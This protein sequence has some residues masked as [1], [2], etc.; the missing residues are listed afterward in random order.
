MRDGH[1]L[2]QRGL[3]TGNSVHQARIEDIRSRRGK[4]NRP[5][6][7]ALLGDSILTLLVVAAAVALLGRADLAGT[8]S[9]AAVPGSAAT[10]DGVPAS[11]GAR[12]EPT[13]TGPVGDPTPTTIPPTATASAVGTDAGLQEVRRQVRE[14]EGRLLPAIRE[15]AM[16]AGEGITTAVAPRRLTDEDIRKAWEISRAP[17]SRQQA[18]REEYFP[19]GSEPWTVGAEINAE[20]VY[21]WGHSAEE[22]YRRY[23]AAYKPSEIRFDHGCSPQ[24]ALDPEGALACS[25]SLQP[26]GRHGGLTYVIRPEW[27]TS[28]NRPLIEYGSATGG[29]RDR[30]VT[31]VRISGTAPTREGLADL[32]VS[33]AFLEGVTVRPLRAGLGSPSWRP[34]LPTSAI[35]AEIEIEV[36]EDTTAQQPLTIEGEVLGRHCERWLSDE[37]VVDKKSRQSGRFQ[38]GKP[39]TV[40]LLNEEGEGTL[41][42]LQPGQYDLRVRLEREGAMR[43]VTVPV[44]LEAAREPVESEAGQTVRQTFKLTVYG[45]PRQGDSI[46]VIAE[47]IGPDGKALGGVAASF[48]VFPAPGDLKPECED[49]RAYA[50]ASGDRVGDLRFTPSRIPVGSTVKYEFFAVLRLEDGPRSETFYT[51]TRKLTS[52]TIVSV[53]YDLDAKRGGVGDGPGKSGR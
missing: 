21:I 53:Y 15:A 4:A 41:C 8:G 52:D 14:M 27:V 17:E 6:K 3:E 40:R 22:T 46:G 25:F 9:K 47:V 12:N 20:G 29:R 30:V 1:S 10:P 49:G 34:G 2:F 51:G 16:M 38:A 23:L 5:R 36:P 33:E 48:C 39:E 50:I 31:V 44:E 37:S 11:D 24:A 35:W 13:P 18:L 42:D 7:S 43:F 26:D 45:K 32:A 28:E 19:G